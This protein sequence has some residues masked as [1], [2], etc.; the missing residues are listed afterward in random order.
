MFGGHDAAALARST[1]QSG[2]QKLYIYIVFN[3]L[4]NIS[5]PP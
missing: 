5:S 3:D 2:P 1:S 4:L